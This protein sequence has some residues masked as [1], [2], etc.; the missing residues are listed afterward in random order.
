MVDGFEGIDDV[1]I[2]EDNPAEIRFIEEA[3]DAA[4][5]DPTIH[6]AT[7]EG[8]AIDVLYQRGEHSDA[9][10]IDLVLLDWHLSTATG[11]DVLEAAKALD[12]EVTVVVMTGSKPELET[13]RS[14]L[15][16]ADE[17]I[18]KQTEPESYMELFHSL[19]DDE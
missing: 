17:C 10:A 11:R 16:G 19:L 14:S 4:E 18:E 3:F 2:V 8:E 9:P 1:L 13:L 6:S 5:H 7:T 15:S 12:H